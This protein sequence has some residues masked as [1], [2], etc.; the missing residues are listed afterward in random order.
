MATPPS[1]PRSTTAQP[2]GASLPP[3]TPAANT[4]KYADV[5][6]A[7]IQVRSGAIDQKIEIA[8][9]QTSAPKQMSV[10]RPCRPLRP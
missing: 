4:A 9:M 2:P 5:R 1:S 6:A 7:S 10:P 8:V 3:A